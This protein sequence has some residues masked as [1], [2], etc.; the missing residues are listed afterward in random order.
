MCLCSSC[1]GSSSDSRIK[2]AV[3]QQLERYPKSTLQDVYKSFFQ[4]RFGAGHIIV[5]RSMA[6]SCLRA[7]LE[8]CGKLSGAV[9]EPTGGEGNFYRVNLSVIKTGQ[10]PYSVF[11]DT[12]VRSAESIPSGKNWADEWLHID[13]VV[14]TMKC[15]FVGYDT[16]RDS[17][18]KLLQ[19]DDWAVHHSQAYRENYN[20]HYRMIKKNIFE[21][22]ILPLITKN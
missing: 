12:F 19:T 11:L 21:R 20:P 7:E 1:S 6:D 8:S 3:A 10:V 17:I 2:Q 15:P 13:S 9:Y 18:R 14:A 22:E 16:D 4:D 5:S